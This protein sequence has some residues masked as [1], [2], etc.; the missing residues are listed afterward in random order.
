MKTLAARMVARLTEKDVEE[1]DRQDYY[2][3][4]EKY[5]KDGVKEESRDMSGL[6]Y[7]LECV[8]GWQYI[9]QQELT[10]E[11]AEY[12]AIMRGLSKLSDC[13]FDPPLTPEVIAKH[14]EVGDLPY[15]IN[16]NLIDLEAAPR[17]VVTIKRFKDMIWLFFRTM[18]A[19]EMKDPWGE[20]Q[21]WQHDGQDNL[22]ECA[23]QN[24]EEMIY[25]RKRWA[26]QENKPIVNTINQTGGELDFSL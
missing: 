23:R 22:L 20:W 3:P 9:K 24:C 25:W 6:L 13:N 16:G 10:A 19:Y 2:L 17:Q 26:E 21:P 1:A 11:N 4:E 7:M 8:F 18:C 14:L 12:K 5:Q 15:D